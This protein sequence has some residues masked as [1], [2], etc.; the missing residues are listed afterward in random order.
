MKKTV[1]TI[2]ALVLMFS[3]ACPAFAANDT[4][5]SVMASKSEATVGDEIEFTV[6]FDKKAGNISV[7]ELIVPINSD[8]FEYVQGSAQKKLPTLSEMLTGDAAYREKNNDMF[9]NWVDIQ[10]T[11]PDSANEIFTFKLK[12]TEHAKNGEHTFGI[13]SESF[14]TDADLEDIFFDTVSCTVKIAGSPETAVESKAPDAQTTPQSAD[15]QNNMADNNGNTAASTAEALADGNSENSGGNNAAWI[16]IA[17]VAVVCV[18]V[19]VIV[20][21][22]KKKKKQ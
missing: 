3:M 2:L 13:S 8:A 10:S 20:L 21:T 19:V 5:I 9:C 1:L 11:I 15:V 18:I 12:V 17:A 14:L 22:G 4:Q 16:I 7:L 6:L